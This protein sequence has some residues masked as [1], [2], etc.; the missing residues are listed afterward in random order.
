M[1]T[2]TDENFMT[3]IAAGTN[4]VKF[5]AN[6]CGPCKALKP[7]LDEVEKTSGISVFEID[8]DDNEKMVQLF[9]IKAVPTVILFKD[10]VAVG[11]PLVGLQSAATY[12]NAIEKSKNDSN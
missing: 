12:L 9:G 10:G 5:S 8:I 6:W 4:I 1:K 2:V 3:T 7:V 11:N